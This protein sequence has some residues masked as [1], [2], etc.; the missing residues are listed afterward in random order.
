MTLSLGMGVAGLSYLED[1]GKQFVLSKEQ[2]LNL[3]MNG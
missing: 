2:I 3:M 1:L